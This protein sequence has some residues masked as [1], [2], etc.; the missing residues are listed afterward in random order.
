MGFCMQPIKDAAYWAAVEASADEIRAHLTQ[1][2]LRRVAF[3]MDVE[4]VEESAASGA[5]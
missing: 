5:A 1:G 4:L 3:I 2:Q